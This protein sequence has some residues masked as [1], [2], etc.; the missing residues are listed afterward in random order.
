LPVN[1]FFLSPDGRTLLVPN[2]LGPHLI[3]YSLHLL[4]AASGHLLRK[5]DPAE[6]ALFKTPINE[7]TA[8]ADG[9]TWAVLAWLDGPKVVL[10]EAAT[11]QQRGL[12]NPGRHRVLAL[13]FS[14]DGR[15]L[16]TG[17]EELHLW[18]LAAGRIAWRGEAPGGLDVTSLAFSPDGTRLAVGGYD[19]AAL[20]YDVGELLGGK[21]PAPPKLSADELENLWTDL[22]GGDG[23]RAYRAV[24]RLAASHQGVPFLGERLAGLPT[25]DERRLARLLADLD[26]NDFA[27]RERATRELERLGKAAEPA[28]RK[29]LE[30]APSAEVRTRV[31]A[32]LAR[33]DRQH[34][35]AERALEALEMAGTAAAREVIKGL[36]GGPPA[37]PLTEAAKAALGRLAARASAAP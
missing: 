7:A 15:L 4:N 21:K 17:G 34:L 30:G 20:V 26:D 28:L 33:C 29:A 5:M 11:G 12:L 32:L 27:V 37:A 36:A 16:A 9:R 19:S 18:D 24:L 8:S 3:G 31:K 35:Q 10:F 25:P 1:R 22:S 2:E 23:A 13:A 14:P 6:A